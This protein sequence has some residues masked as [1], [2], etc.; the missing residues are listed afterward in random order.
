MNIHASRFHAVSLVPILT[1]CVF[2]AGCNGGSKAPSA[3]PVPMVQNLNNATTPSSQVGLPIEINGSGF[4]S[5][6]GKVL[7]T[8]GSVSVPAT[9]SPGAWSSTLISVVVPA[10]NSSGQFTVPGTVLVSVETSGGTSNV[11]ELNLVP[12]VNFDPAAITWNTTIPLPTPLSGLRAVAVTSNSA[13]SAWV[14][15]TGGYNGSVNTTTVMSNVLG[16]DGRVGPSWTAT[17]VHSLP[18]PLAHHGMA[19]ADPTNSPVSL[20][21]RFIYTLG[22]QVLSTSQPGGTSSV[23][24]AKVNPD[25]GE[26][27]VWLQLPTN[28]PQSLIG[29]AV[30]VF[31]GY[32][33][34]IGGLTINQSPS[35]QIYVSKIQP[36]GS[37]GL[38][39]TAANHLPV[40]VAFPTA[41]VYAENLYV[42]GGDSQNSNSPNVPG[43]G[44]ITDVHWASAINGF[45]GPWI[46]TNP[47]IKG[48]A[49]QVTWLFSGRVIDAEGVYQDLYQSSSNFLPMEHTVINPDATVAPWIGLPSSSNLPSGVNLFNAAGIVS[50]ILSST[51][52]PR[53]LLLGGEQF[54]PLTSGVLS[55]QVYFNQTP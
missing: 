18:V 2:L 48:R 47:T 32:V 49:K 29:P 46:S 27:G 37:L 36:D 54:S 10:G 31:N 38:W 3:P 14:V 13:T 30:V 28:L 11:I 26:V 39:F 24:V 23:Y 20:G 43:S 33:Y 12:T 53:F 25:T 41:F 17:V 15:I 22:G 9:P 5:S 21:S 7:F 4:Q 16:S 50:P 55:D 1:L 35:S 45:I 19:E 6:P 8:Q 42:L 51:N 52:T 34:V 44:G 40:P